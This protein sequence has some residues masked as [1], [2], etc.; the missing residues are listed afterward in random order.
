MADRPPGPFRFE[1]P[2][3]VPGDLACAF[4]ANAIQCY[5]H[6]AEGRGNTI[7]LLFL[8]I[9]WVARAAPQE[10]YLPRDALRALRIPWSPQHTLDLLCSMRDHEGIMKRQAPPEGPA[11]K[12]PCP[13]GSGKKYK[14]CCEEKDAAASSTET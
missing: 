1:R 4:M 9:P 6:R 10:L 12:G 14:R 5:L 3:D 7:A 2:E 13:C 11:R 8:M